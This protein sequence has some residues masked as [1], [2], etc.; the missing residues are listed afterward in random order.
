MVVMLTATDVRPGDIWVPMNETG[1]FLFMFLVV[2]VEDTS[3][4]KSYK[5]AVTY[6]DDRSRLRVAHFYNNWDMR[7]IEFRRVLE[8]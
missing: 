8:Q 6:L 7:I 4:H 2:A 5:R 1:E 3:G